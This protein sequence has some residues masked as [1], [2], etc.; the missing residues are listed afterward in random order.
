MSSE[1]LGYDKIKDFVTV[2]NL[3]I[4]RSE[5]LRPAIDSPR[6]YT[7]QQLQDILNGMISRKLRAVKELTKEEMVRFVT[8][9]VD[10]L[11]NQPDIYARYL[12]P[13]SAIDF[14]SQCFDAA[15]HTSYYINGDWRKNPSTQA[16]QKAYWAAR[17]S[18]HSG[19]PSSYLSR[20]E[21]RDEGAGYG[22]RGGRGGRERDRG[23][24]RDFG[25]F[26]DPFD[27]DHY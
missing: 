24:Q 14:F 26:S 3:A 4:H 2:S 16:E 7:Q 10:L 1:T 6:D 11:R 5:T 13:E 9:E 20:Y 23:D 22:G 27:G 19:T 8:T 12:S 15:Q 18:S 17:R 25:R 21:D